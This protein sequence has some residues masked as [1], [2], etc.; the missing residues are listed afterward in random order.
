MC[1]CESPTCGSPAKHPLTPNGV[2]GATTDEQVIR[3]WWSEAEIANVGIATGKGLLV[4]DIDAKHGGLESLAQ[5]E[6]QHGPLPMTPTVATGGGSRHY[7]FRLPD[8]VMVGNRAG[9][10]AGIDVRS[11]GGYVVAPPSLHASGQRYEWLVPPDK[12]LAE[13]PQW[14]LDMVNGRIGTRCASATS[15]SMTL[16]VQPATADLATHAGVGEG[17]RNATLCRLI[18]VHL[19]RGDDPEAI[20]PLA[21]AWAERCSP[22]MD[23]AEVLRTL[24]SLAAKHQRSSIVIFSKTSEADDLDALPLPEPP[25]WPTLDEAALHGVPGEIV[26]ILEPET[27][28]DPVGILLSMLVMFG[29]VVGRGPFFAVEGDQHPTNLFTVLVGETSRGRK[30][31]SLG[32]TLALFDGADPEWKRDC[33]NQPFQHEFL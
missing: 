7:Y 30:G 3:R 28:A 8:G 27:E 12:P 20:E 6:V 26:R 29:N 17:Q 9:V 25:Q 15:D 14:L 31:T 22:P 4:L 18:G 2:H 23:Q 21:L 1:T 11:D 5:L 19:A 13:A 24:N 10:A 32:R 33:I 16:T